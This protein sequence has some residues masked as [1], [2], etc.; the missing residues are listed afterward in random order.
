[1]NNQEEIEMLKMEKELY[2]NAFANL[3]NAYSVISAA[4]FRLATST[5]KD[6]TM[7]YP[8]LLPS[9]DDE[10]DEMIHAIEMNEKLPK[11][12]FKSKR[13]EESYLG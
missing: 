5:R 1:M 13:S 10:Y 7:I 4:Y 2:H 12:N 6:P 3:L 11:L 8:K 9:V